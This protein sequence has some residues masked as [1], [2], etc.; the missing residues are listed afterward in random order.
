MPIGT[1]PCLIMCACHY[2]AIVVPAISVAEAVREREGF[3]AE[4]VGCKVLMRPS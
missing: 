1:A 4:W 3:V 2:A